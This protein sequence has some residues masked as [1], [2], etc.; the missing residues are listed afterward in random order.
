LSS[1]NIAYPIDRPAQS[2]YQCPA[3]RGARDRYRRATCDDD[4]RSH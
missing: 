2:Q 3:R 4:S 1:A